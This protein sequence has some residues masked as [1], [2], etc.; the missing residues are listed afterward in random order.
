MELKN[1]VKKVL[2]ILKLHIPNP[3]T[4]LEY[5]TP[6]QLMV[7]VILSAQCTD[8]RVNEITPNLFQKFPDAK[9][10]AKA[11]FDEV[12]PLI[13][14]ISYPNN[15]TKHL[16]EASKILV[17]K[18]N[19]KIPD[20]LEDLILI[21]GVGRKTANVLLS[22]LYNKPALAVDTHVQRV[23]NRL[24]WVN[25]QNVLQIE[26]ILTQLINPNEIPIAHHLLIL[27][28]RYT[29]KA[30]NP[31]CTDCPIQKYCDFFQSK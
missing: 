10:F 1:K 20:N 12:F 15:K 28:G 21:P 4:E 17:D 5:Q 30:K 24:G 23:A 8:K 27:H 7:A 29:C 31:N 9:S 22:V 18:Y 3:V 19:E 26:K 16:I 2:E 6:F 13:K 11:S 14:S 25:T